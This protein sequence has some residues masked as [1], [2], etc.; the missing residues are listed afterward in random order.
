M[1][2]FYIYLIAGL[3]FLRFGQD[4][5]FSFS[6]F[7]QKC[8]DLIPEKDLEILKAISLGTESLYLDKHPALKQRYLF[9][10][11][12]RNE[13]VKIRASRKKIDAANYLRGDGYVEPWLSHIAINAYRNPSPI[14]AEKILDAARWQFLDELSLGHYFDLEYLVAYA[15]KL[16]ILER[17]QK[18]QAA[19][20][21][22]ALEEVL[23]QKLIRAFYDQ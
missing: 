11:A 16:L 21:A 8:A 10:R 17:W 7:L 5:P 4:A 3:P 14:E 12:L 19:D 13:L 6:V 22:K 23:T 2:D 18:V 15:Y 1:A 9:E 20:K